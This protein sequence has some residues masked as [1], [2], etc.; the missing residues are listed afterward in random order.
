VEADHELI[1]QDAG[2]IRQGLWRIARYAQDAAEKLDA[3]IED[4]DLDGKAETA[5]VR[6]DLEWVQA[7]IL[8]L[9]EKLDAY[10]ERHGG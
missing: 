5:Q 7:L 10:Q 8:E 2:S 1:L 6:E 9:S 4:E 3:R